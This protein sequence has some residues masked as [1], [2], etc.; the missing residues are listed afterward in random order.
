MRLPL[1]LA[2]MIGAT[3]ALHAKQK[4]TTVVTMQGH[5]TKFVVDNR[6]YPCKTVIYMHL[7]NGRTNFNLTTPNGAIMLSGGADSQ[8][9]P[10]NYILEVDTIRAGRS[11]G[12]SEGFK[13]KGRCMMSLSVDGDYVHS[14]TCAATGKT[15][16]VTVEFVGDGSKVERGSF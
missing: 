13:V 16:A 2:L 14:L 5:C 1:V 7:A 3:S 9:D 15:K 10:T 11:D 4:P 12:Q 8:P 6:S